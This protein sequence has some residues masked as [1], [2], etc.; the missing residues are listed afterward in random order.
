MD[1]WG[2]VGGKGGRQTGTEGGGRERR[3]A[4]RGE[5][6]KGKKGRKWVEEREREGV[7]EGGTEGVRGWTKG[8]E[9]RGRMVVREGTA[10]AILCITHYICLSDIHPIT[11]LLGR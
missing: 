1:I 11:S 6:W 8:E 2:S 5:R 3:G 9:E 4:R 7:D 10:V